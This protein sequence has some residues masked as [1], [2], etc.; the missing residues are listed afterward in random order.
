[1]QELSKSELSLLLENIS[2]EFDLLSKEEQ[3]EVLTDLAEILRQ[4]KV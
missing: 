3:L 2:T 1:M 4:I